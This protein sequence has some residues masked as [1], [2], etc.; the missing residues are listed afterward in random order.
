MSTLLFTG[1]LSASQTHYYLVKKSLFLNGIDNP[2]PIQAKSIVLSGWA[3]T[4]TPPYET[5]KTA[6]IDTLN[7]RYIIRPDSSN[8]FTS[9]TAFDTAIV[10]ASIPHVRLGADVG[11]AIN[12]RFSIGG[13]VLLSSYYNNV[14]ANNAARK[15]FE[16]INP[17]IGVWVSFGSPMDSANCKLKTRFTMRTL[18]SIDNYYRYASQ[19][20]LMPD[21]TQSLFS[22][23]NV[24]FCFFRYELLTSPFRYF[25]QWT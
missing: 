9:D 3:E 1:C 4:V 11:F 14:P 18:F 15:Q 21:S 2:A 19:D 12:S 24:G 5:K 8:R 16:A 6:W 17:A 22:I 20:T 10:S 13:T 7:Y 23:E 25:G